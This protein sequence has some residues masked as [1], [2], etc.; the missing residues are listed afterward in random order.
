MTEE[1][2]LEFIMPF[3]AHAGE[4]IG[5]VPIDYLKYLIDNDI[6]TGSGTLKDILEHWEEEIMGDKEWFVP[7]PLRQAVNIRR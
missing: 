1:D 2:M 6:G 5:D 7:P 3:G 4:A